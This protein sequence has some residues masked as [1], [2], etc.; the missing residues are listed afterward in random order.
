MYSRC[1]NILFTAIAALLLCSSCQ[2]EK[3]D[4]QPSPTRVAVYGDAA[5]QSTLR[6][7]GAIGRETIV[8]N[9]YNATAYDISEGQRLYDWFNCSGCHAAGG[10]GIGPPLIKTN[11]VYGGEPANLFD[12]IV[13]GRPNGMP[14]WGGRI[15]EYQIWQIVAYVR[16]MNG[17]QPSSAT[18]ARPDALESNPQNL[19]NRVPGVTK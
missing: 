2:R 1:P 10:G 4:L 17:L 14:S 19:Q 16:S 7:G 6:P 11:W 13:K 18:S 8:T 3:R 9:P 12:T 5:R 15:P